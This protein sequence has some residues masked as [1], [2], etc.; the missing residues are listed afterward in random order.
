MTEK[1]PWWRSGAAYDTLAAI[2]LSI[3]A[4][5]TSWAT[6]QAALWD[7]EQAS[8]YTQAGATRTRAGL[9]ATENGQFQG[10]DLFLFTQWLN[11]YASKDQLLQRFYYERFRPE[12]R[13]AFDAWIALEPMH[14]PKAPHSPFVMREYAPRLAVEAAALDKRADEQFE[15]GQRF[16]DIS[17]AYVAATVIFA[18]S[19][20]IGGIAQTFDRKHLAG[21]LTLLGAAACVYGLLRMAI[22]PTMSL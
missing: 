5:L 3:S 4:L 16:N 18:L 20:F 12:F 19:L 11:A 10:A 1:E 17:D 7:G 2:V 22:L 6:F 13:Q 21:A 14:N 15:R 8:A 9:L